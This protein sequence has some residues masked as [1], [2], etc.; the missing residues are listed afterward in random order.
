MKCDTEIVFD[1]IIQRSYFISHMFVYVLKSLSILKKHKWDTKQS[2]C[3]ERFLTGV[4][5]SLCKRVCERWSLFDPELQRLISIF[6]IMLKRVLFESHKIHRRRAFGFTTNHLNRIPDRHLR[7][8]FPI[9]NCGLL[10]QPVAY[11][12]CV[13]NQRSTR[14][15]SITFSKRLVH[16]HHQQ[17]GCEPFI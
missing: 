6:Y 13:I 3:S 10:L 9:M 14:V 11:T 16:M 8:F 5:A 2:E 15:T 7:S 1:F 4:F 12:V 17:H